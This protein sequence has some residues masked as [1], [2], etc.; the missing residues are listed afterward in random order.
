MTFWSDIVDSQLWITRNSP[1]APGIVS[2]VAR[3]VR[4]DFV[5]TVRVRARVP[6]AEDVDTRRNSTDFGCRPLPTACGDYWEPVLGGVPD[7]GI[8]RSGSLQSPEMFDFL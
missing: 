5:A 8:S 4:D 6:S 3:G 7:P 2:K 1:V